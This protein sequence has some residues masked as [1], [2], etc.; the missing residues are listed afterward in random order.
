MQFDTGARDSAV[1]NDAMHGLMFLIDTRL[2]STG[3]PRV[4]TGFPGCGHR[5]GH[6]QLGDS[7]AALHAAA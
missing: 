6:N 7:G 1:S 4:C 2:I 3:D 5:P